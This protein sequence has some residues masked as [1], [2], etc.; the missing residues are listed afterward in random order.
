[1]EWITDEFIRKNISYDELINELKLAF[2]ENV[3]QCPSKVAYDYKSNTSEKNNTFLF[4]PAWDNQKYFGIKLITAT[5]NN[6]H[7]DLPYI[8]GLYLLLNAENGLPMAIMDAKLITNIRTAATSILA[9]NFLAKKEASKVLIL[10]N[11]SLSP[12]YIKGYASKASVKEIYVWGLNFEISK[13]IAASINQETDVKIEAV[14]DFNT[15]IKD[16]DIISC[17]TSSNE[18]FIDK[19]HVSTGQHFDLVGSYTETMQE[20][21]TDV[22]SACSVYVDN[23]GITLEHSGEIVNAMKENKLTK[24]SIKGDLIFLCQDDVHKRASNTE[25]TLFKCTGMAIEDLVI[26]QLIYKRYVQSRK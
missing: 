9:S 13:Q 12:Y 8:N 23:L 21:T 14:E 18:P 2:R 26:A 7:V 1:M 15:V 24:S 10:G 25:N 6:S 20:A 11:G 3:I 17:I 16:A 22:V 5:P 4:M 19:Q